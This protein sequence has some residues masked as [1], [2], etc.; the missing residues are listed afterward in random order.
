M[1]Q[2]VNIGA[3]ISKINANI[4]MIV[5]LSI[6]PKGLKG[7]DSPSLKDVDSGDVYSDG[8]NCNYH[9]RLLSC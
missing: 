1:A 5:S 9:D 8:N 2:A 3:T 4:I 7:L 6:E